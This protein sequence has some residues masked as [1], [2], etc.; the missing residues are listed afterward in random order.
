MVRAPNLPQQNVVH[1]GIGGAF[2]RKRMSFPPAKC[3]AFRR[4]D[5]LFCF[6]VTLILMLSVTSRAAPG[7]GQP[8]SVTRGTVYPA[9]TLV[10]LKQAVNAAN[11]AGLPATILVSNGVYVLDV[12]TLN[13]TCPGLVIRSASGDREA[14][15]IRGPDEGPSA[16]L[17]NVFSVS[18]TNVVIADLTFGYCR[19]HGIQVHGE[20]S[21]NAAGLWVHNCRIVNCNEQFIKGS[22]GSGSVGARDGLI[23]HCLFEFTSGWAYQYYTGGIDIHKGVNWTVRDNLF[24]NLRVPSGQTGIAEHAVHFWNRAGQPQNVIVERNW[25]INCDRG[26]GFGLGGFAGGFNGGNSRIRNTF[27]YNDGTGPSTDVGI[28]L[29][30]ASGVAVDNNTLFNVTYWAPMEYRFADSTNVVI[31]NNLVNRTIARRDGAT[32]ATRSNNVENAQSS[33]FKNAAIGDLHLLPTATQALDQGLV[34]TEFSNDLDGETRPAGSGWD[35]GADE[36]HPE[37]ADSDGDGMTDA[38]ELWAGLNP[39]SSVGNDGGNADPDGDGRKNFEE[40]LT[41]THPTN[42]ASVLRLSQVSITPSGPRVFWQGGVNAEQR[43]ERLTAPS[44][45]TATVIF[46]NAPPTSA[47]GDFTDVWT[48]GGGAFYRISAKRPQ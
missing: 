6:I 5:V 24:R 37:R 9:S 46:T 11:A 22:V 34:M 43:L 20:S 32:L 2:L 8:L 17:Q 28:G 41:D 39:L 26:I 4:L 35:V 7:Y 44:S 12:P 13:I 47:T 42:A 38:W 14:V 31:R 29:E 21:Q 10:Q 15:V 33:W 27:V 19:W 36:Y 16:S 3:A 1:R 25:I 45:A 40:Y 23:E 18:A 48:G 30:S